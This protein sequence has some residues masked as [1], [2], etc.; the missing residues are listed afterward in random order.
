MSTTV[1]VTPA[2]VDAAKAV[3]EWSDRLGQP[4]PESVRQIAHASMP[5]SVA[6]ATHSVNGS[7]NGHPDPGD[8]V[9]NG[10]LSLTRV[11]E[12]LEN[13]RSELLNREKA[14]RA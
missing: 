1:V 5:K 8:G 6:G 4:V 14:A 3:V 10:E 12:A 2:Q 11:I 13:L 7:V 9:R